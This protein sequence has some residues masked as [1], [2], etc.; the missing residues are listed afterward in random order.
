[1][2][3][4]AAAEVAFSGQLSAIS[5]IS[6]EGFEE[7]PFEPRHESPASWNSPGFLNDLP[8]EDQR[9]IEAAIK[10]PMEFIACDSDGRAELKFADSTGVFHFIYVDLAYVRELEAT[11]SRKLRTDS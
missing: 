5:C 8:I 3:Y 1:M 6:H 9:A 2:G 11:D 7:V 4:V 10:R